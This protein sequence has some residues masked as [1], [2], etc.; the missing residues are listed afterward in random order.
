MTDT[1]QLSK[2]CSASNW[3]SHPPLKL[4]HNPAF[5]LLCKYRPIQKIVHIS[6][7][8]PISSSSDHTGNHTASITQSSRFPF[9]LTHHPHSRRP[10]D[11][12]YP[13]TPESS[14]PLLP[15]TL[16]HKRLQQIPSPLPLPLFES[17]GVPLKLTNIP[18]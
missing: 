1:T 4:S 12:I 2:W 5:R 18:Q 11:T 6:I 16:Y 7:F 9:V 17:T 13:P 3:A 8:R 14:L 15:P 10:N